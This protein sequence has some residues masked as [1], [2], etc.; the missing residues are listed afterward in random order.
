M[1]GI[2]DYGDREDYGLIGRAAGAIKDIA[3]SD[4]PA[5]GLLN[6]QTTYLQPDQATGLPQFDWKKKYEYD[7]DRALRDGLS[8]RDIA[9]QLV[10]RAQ[11]EPER[12]DKKQILGAELL[13]D[14]APKEIIKTFARVEDVSAMEN[15]GRGLLRGAPAAE[16]GFIGARTLAPLGLATFGPVGGLVAGAVGLIGGAILGD[17]FIGEKLER[18]I[19]G[20]KPQ[21]L[22]GE[23][24][25]SEMAY[26]TG[27]ILGGGRTPAVLRQ[28]P[29]DLGARE[30]L[31]A[32][33]AERSMAARERAA[34]SRTR[35]NEMAAART[36]QT[37]TT[38]V[39]AQ[40][41]LE[42]VAR[43]N[44][45]TQSINATAERFQNMARGVYD[46][47]LKT[48]AFVERIAESAAKQK[49]VPFVI[50]EST[51][52]GMAGVFG[53]VAD[54]MAP[55]DPYARFAG[56]LTG[57]FVGALMPARMLAGRIKDMFTG[58]TELMSESGRRRNLGERLQR[59]MFKE[60][61]D[62]REAEAR[63]AAAESG[64]TYEVDP[65]T[66]TVMTV[67]EF[68]EELDNMV[69]LARTEA[70]VAEA[71]GRA[72]PATAQAVSKPY[73]N[74]LQSDFIGA[75]QALSAQA[76]E[77]ADQRLQSI[78]RALEVKGNARDPASL[79][80]FATLRNA[81]YEGLLSARL[82]QETAR[83][84]EILNNIIP[85]DPDGLPTI[86]SMTVSKEMSE[87]VN[88]VFRTARR[89][90]RRLWKQIEQNVDVSASNT[91]AKWAEIGEKFENLGVKFEKDTQFRTLPS[92]LSEA[93]ETGASQLS[94]DNDASLRRA[95]NTIRNLTDDDPN[96]EERF[97]KLLEDTKDPSKA[98]TIGFGDPLDDTQSI[99][100]QLGDYLENY[101]KRYGKQMSA[102]ERSS[103]SRLLK[104]IRALQTKERVT[105]ELNKAL[106]GG[107][108]IP[109]A[110]TSGKLIDYRSNLL[111]IARAQYQANPTAAHFA[112]EMADAVLDDLAFANLTVRRGENTGD[113]LPGYDNARAFSFK[114]NEVF[115]RSFVGSVIGRNKDGSEVISPELVSNKLFSGTSDYV[116]LKTREMERAV[117]FLAEENPEAYAD[118]TKQN[119]LSY[120]Q[121]ENNLIRLLAD[122]LIVDG[123]VSP[124]RL[125]NFRHKNKA[126]MV[127]FPDIEADIQ[128]AE[129]AERL[130]RDFEAGRQYTGGDKDV[131]QRFT[132]A[133]QDR[134]MAA[135]TQMFKDND[136]PSSVIEMSI[137][138]PVTREN[139][140]IATP[141]KNLRNLIN[142][143]KTQSPTQGLA[144]DLERRTLLETK[145]SDKKNKLIELRNQKNAPLSRIARE[146][147]AIEKLEKDLSDINARITSA[148][149]ADVIE[150]FPI[151]G[152]TE[153]QE[154]RRPATT[155][156]VI[157]ALGKLIIE[158]AYLYAGGMDPDK[159][160][161]P[162]DMDMFLFRPMGQGNPSVMQL[163]ET[164]GIVTSKQVSELE[165]L[166]RDLEKAAEE[167]YVR[168]E[169]LV[170]LI[171]DP[172]NKGLQ[173]M[174][175]SIGASLGAAAAKGPGTGGELQYAALGAGF[176]DDVIL[177]VPRKKQK[178]LMIQIMKEPEEFA[179]LME[180][181]RN[182][183]KEALKK[184]EISGKEGVANRI[185][186]AVGNFFINTIGVSLATA[187]IR[188]S[189]IKG[190]SDISSTETEKA[191]TDLRGD[192][193]E[194]VGIPRGGLLAEEKEP[195][196][197]I[198]PAARELSP[199][200]ATSLPGPARPVSP[201]R[202]PS[203]LE[204]TGPQRPSY[205]P[206]A[207]APAPSTAPTATR[208]RM[209]ELFPNDPV[210]GTRS[211]ITSLIG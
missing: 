189:F 148:K 104:Y 61:M 3:S 112:R 66:G 58:A 136:V 21:G 18:D 83:T 91:V 188:Q 132:L 198:E 40:D 196:P 80:S 143:V 151:P 100:T 208:Q 125:A 111:D 180:E 56:E 116:S 30:A 42:N 93:L 103:N 50:G 192:L 159:G 99:P 122:A 158:K 85:R 131:A 24:F 51:V 19:L 77:H 26:T 106:Q 174:I 169:G 33:Q 60:E 141:V 195:A 201:R 176:L 20:A 190:L 7:I 165:T 64:T 87:L 41:V 67:D 206:R 16:V 108:T 31:A 96:L 204:N 168:G 107:E 88:R 126:L 81:Y 27:Y 185:A 82:A 118:I 184:E 70:Q 113:L 65:N 179:D 138:T 210:L 154:V 178:D 156:N 9:S 62:L 43:R 90:E 79:K 59:G 35:A 170:S 128:T 47:P 49:G 135:L 37:D 114:L 177:R 164:E 152:S 161:R 207:P 172:V 14:F 94:R 139:G 13:R 120:S 191:A 89:E 202:E 121:I 11:S 203:Y 68:Y 123:R 193:R 71:E 153:V 38:V 25:S 130:L 84:T 63:R 183:V 101:I 92:V 32:R 2:F 137:G 129:G 12:F 171:D 119:M 162:R 28:H 6:L 133:Q 117:R 4:E 211:G 115:K 197:M 194:A 102:G 186:N 74:E 46:M 150:K 187:A 45:G 75:N 182:G 144:K 48:V 134:D 145:I 146:E 140:A 124:T 155:A 29:L 57:G 142:L 1:S 157:D 147:N 17:I 160:F 73:L 54:E 52:A 44:P 200:P 199:K 76:R 10:A 163:L 39:A 55:G 23:R 166:L 149:E 167:S 175:R 98:R 209:S 53:A 34:A 72:I 127:K 181:V 205:V 5:P 105:G 69:A 109:Y 36:N 95:T 22:P 78:V 8:V 173:V 15:L 110:T 97:V 86:D